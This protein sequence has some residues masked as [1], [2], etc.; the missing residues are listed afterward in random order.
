MQRVSATV[1]RE[2]EDF[3][4]KSCAAALLEER[5]ASREEIH[6]IAHC[7]YSAQQHLSER[8]SITAAASEDM[9]ERHAQKNATPAQRALLRL[10]ST[11]R[12]AK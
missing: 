12:S 7:R 9:G 2:R 11:S 5:I 6:H 4:L 10:T 8:Q 1:A 3:D